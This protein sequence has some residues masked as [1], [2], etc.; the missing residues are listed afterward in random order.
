MIRACQ[1]HSIYFQTPRTPDDL[2][3][4][5][6]YCAPSLSGL[7]LQGPWYFK[8]HLKEEPE[9]CGR[10]EPGQNECLHWRSGSPVSTVRREALRL[11]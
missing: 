1:R 10:L 6:A 11:F 2:L 7:S 4:R 3:L 8:G 5:L 9:R